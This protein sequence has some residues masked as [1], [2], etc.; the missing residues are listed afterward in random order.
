MSCRKRSRPD[1]VMLKERATRPPSLV[2]SSC[3]ET[4]PSSSSLVRSG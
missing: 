2:V 1:A 4:R 3:T